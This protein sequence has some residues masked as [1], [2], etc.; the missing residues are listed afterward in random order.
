MTQ[1]QALEEYYLTSA[2]FNFLFQ[3]SVEVVIDPDRNTLGNIV[4]C[5]R[6][7]SSGEKV[8]GSD[9]Y[10]VVQ[11]MPSGLS[12]EYCSPQFLHPSSLTNPPYRSVIRQIPHLTSDRVC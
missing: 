8:G 1:P 10:L 2:L 3:L 4:A 6:Q 5:S 12:G 7:L 11:E 9:M